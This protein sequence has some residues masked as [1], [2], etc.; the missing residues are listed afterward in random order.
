NQVVQHL[1]MLGTPNAG[2]PWP[3]IQAWAT[4]GLS[5]ILNAMTGVAWPAVALGA[6]LKGVEAID[7][8][9]DQMEPTSQFYKDLAASG[10][11]KVPYTI[12]AGN[13]SLLP[14]AL[15]LAPGQQMSPVERLLDR[16]SLHNVK[17]K[18]IDIAFFQQPNDIAVS[19]ASIT[20]V[21]RDR[22]P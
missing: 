7:V 15:Q 3:T 2:S 16:L 13:T 21:P 22:S 14:A 19:V 11:P 18:L 4:V 20:S 8:A 9:L 12:L 10:D 6:L 17:Q 5:F 1:I